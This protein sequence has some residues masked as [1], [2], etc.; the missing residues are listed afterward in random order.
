MIRNYSGI[1]ILHAR[2]VIYPLSPSACQSA[3][4]IL[5]TTVQALHV[6]KMIDKYTNIAQVSGVE[7]TVAVGFV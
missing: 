5:C 1:N 2:D 7:L 6:R 4:V 3:D